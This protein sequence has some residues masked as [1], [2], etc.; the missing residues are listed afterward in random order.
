[1][2][3]IKLTC[4]LKRLVYDII[5]R[6]AL[7][8]HPAQ[9]LICLVVNLD[10]V[11]RRH[12]D[13]HARTTHIPSEL[14][15]PNTLIMPRCE[16]VAHGDSTVSESPTDTPT[17][18]ADSLAD[19]LESDDAPPPEATADDP[20]TRVPFFDVRATGTGGVVT[21]RAGWLTGDGSTDALAISATVGIG[22]AQAAMG[23]ALTWY[24]EQL[25]ALAADA[26][27]GGEGE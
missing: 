7:R 16:Y 23:L 24:T 5:E 21:V 10:R 25:R 4:H 9:C 22:Q 6:V 1:M 11:V 12:M 13:A 8:F 14:G 3:L 20:T 18:A 17:D 19:R 15:S 26:N 2:L 27:G